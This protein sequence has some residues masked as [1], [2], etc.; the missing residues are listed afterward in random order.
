MEY[1]NVTKEAFNVAGIRA[2][3]EWA[4]GVWGIVKADGSMERM[5]QIAGE[6]KVTLG[7][8]FGFDEKGH[9]DNMVG[10]FTE[11]DKVE[12]YEVVHY[13]ESK[14]IELVTEGKISDNVLG[15]AWQYI[16]AEL[17]DKNVITQR[18][19]PTIEDYAIWDEQ[20]DYCKVVISVAVI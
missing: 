1:R 18:D 6:S 17:I 20:N 5:Q 2:V 16:H 12:D 4:G 15:N 10:F 8:C 14:W 19:V 7:L 3:T 13:P 9:N 11:L